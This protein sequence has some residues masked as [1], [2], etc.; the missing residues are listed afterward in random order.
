MTKLRHRLGFNL[1]DTFARHSVDLA[2]FIKSLGLSISKTETHRNDACFAF[3]E[4]VENSVDWE[5]GATDAQLNQQI[6]CALGTGQEFYNEL[7]KA[8]GL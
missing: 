2:N 7:A 4:G 6:A 1:T 5:H 3:R 8:L